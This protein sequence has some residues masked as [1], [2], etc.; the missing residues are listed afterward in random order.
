[1]GVACAGGARADRASGP[2]DLGRRWTPAAPRWLSRR[3]RTQGAAG[4]NMVQVGLR[5][6]QAPSGTCQRRR[7][8]T[9]AL[10]HGDRNGLTA[11]RD[12]LDASGWRRTVHGERGGLLHRTAVAASPPQ[13]TTTRIFSTPP[14]C[15]ECST[16]AATAERPARCGSPSAHAACSR[17][18]ARNCCSPSRARD[19]GPGPSD[20]RA[21]PTYGRASS[22]QIS[23]VRSRDSPA[24]LGPAEKYTSPVSRSYTT[25]PTSRARVSPPRRKYR[26]VV[27]TVSACR[28]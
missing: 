15:V 18:V 12:G 11:T 27:A 20:V 22:A 1:M 13:R 2:A 19:S 24:S 16:G 28:S 21:D 7:R 8:S 5:S 9:A 4:R 10:C 26:P 6:P 25:R 3:S 14:A 23:G 17:R